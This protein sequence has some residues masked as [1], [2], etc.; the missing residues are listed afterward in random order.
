MVT[1]RTLVFCALVLASTS[2]F[3]QTTPRQGG[4]KLS[5]TW[6]GDFILTNLDG[7]TSHDKAVLVLNQHGSILSGS[8]GA[9][10]DQQSPFV[11][12]RVDNGNIRFHLDVGGGMDF[13]L[14]LVAGYLRGAANGK[15]SRAEVVLQP[16]PGLLSHGELMEEI[17][18]ADRNLFDAFSTCNVTR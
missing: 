15:S 7:K 14:Q 16:A 3:A 11:D 9:T 2:L 17:L 4:L 12:G 18:N 6:F 10:V 1:I 8:I 5:G 13:R